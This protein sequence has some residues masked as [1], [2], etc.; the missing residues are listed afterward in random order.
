MRKA[1]TIAAREYESVVRTKSF[2]V[3]ILVM[4]LMMGG[5]LIFQVLLKNQGNVAE[6]RFAVIDRTPGGKLAAV[7]EAKAK[8]W[9][10]TAIFDPETKKQIKSAFVIERVEPSLPD[11]ESM[12]RQRF[13]LSERVRSKELFGFRLAIEAGRPLHQLRQYLQSLLLATGLAERHG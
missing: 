10:E 1:L 7:L 4:P 11:A 2:I 5:S 8:Q 9:N 3:S 13:D 12:K 6:K